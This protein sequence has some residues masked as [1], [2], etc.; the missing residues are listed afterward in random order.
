MNPPDIER[1]VTAALQA[2]AEDAMNRSDTTTDQLETLLRISGRDTQRRR[3]LHV[4]G[5]LA[6]AAV[7]AVVAVLV[8]PREAGNTPPPVNPPTKTAEVTDAEHVAAGFI[9]ALAAFD[10]GT[11][12]A[13]VA[14]GAQLRLASAM[15]VDGSTVPWSLRN[16]WDEATGWQV[17]D[18]EGCHGT[19]VSSADVDVRCAF[20][21]HQLGSDALSR[22]PFGDNVLAVTVQEGAIT[23]ARLTTAHVTNGF[24]DT[25]WDPF[26]AWMDEAHPND[27][28][29]MAA[30]ED[31]H[32][33]SARVQ[34]SLRLWEQRTQQYVDAV[35]AGRAQ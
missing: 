3:R 12:K 15:G 4:A 11:A 20:T 28:A 13:Y 33:G 24:S 29:V 14:D 27:E 26:W 17:T 10:R 22:G 32:A 5:A 9:G 16:R 19:A 34:R 21:A 30:F 8:W 1:L 23:D 31:P 35:Q 2:D 6:V 25:M 18:L 7:V